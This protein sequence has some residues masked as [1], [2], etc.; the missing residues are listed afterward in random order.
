MSNLY[1]GI[2]IN[3]GSSPSSTMKPTYTLVIINEEGQVV[4][5]NTEA[6]LSRII[7]LAWENRVTSIAVD[8][9][10]EL[11]A[12][13]RDIARI[14]SLLPPHTKLVQVT[15][16]DG[17]LYTLREL[18]EK[19][20]IRIGHGK[21]PPG[22][23]AYLAALLSSKGIGTPVGL[24]GSRTRIIIA[25]RRSPRSGGWS[26]ARYRRRVNTVIQNVARTIKET[27]EREGLEFDETYR[28]SSGGLE[29][30]V[31]TVYSDIGTVSR[32]IRPYRGRD[33]QIKLKPV[34]KAHITIG[35]K[36]L[37][38]EKP[39]IIGIDP[40]ISTGI[41]ILDIDGNVLA[42]ESHRSMDRAA[43]ASLIRS[44]GTPVIVATDVKP[45]PEAVRKIAAFFNAQLYVP[46]DNLSSD[47]KRLIASTVAPDAKL[48]THQRDALAAAYKAYKELREKF[49]QAELYL[50]KVKITV[51]LDRVKE[52][53]AKGHAIAEAVEKE[54]DRI[55]GVR[56][57]RPAPLQTLS[58]QRPETP[59]LQVIAEYKEK[60]ELLE[61][62]NRQ[63]RR[64]I[65]DLEEEIER[66]ENDYRARLH[67]INIE[68]KKRIAE[69]G[70]YE[71]IKKLES[72]L[73]E[74]RRS[75]NNIRENAARLEEAIED[76]RAGRVVAARRV[77]RFTRDGLREALS[78]RPLS[79]QDI[80][81]LENQSV[82]DERAIRL[83]VEKDVEAV[84]V[85]KIVNKRLVTA[86][87]SRGVPVIEARGF[88]VLKS[89]YNVLLES[90]I[91]E[92]I[93]RRRLE[94]GASRLT[95]ETLERMLNA[96][97]LK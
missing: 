48:D 57:S 58:P 85:D 8:N 33:Y 94:I 74:A 1:M 78:E 47:E 35:T 97:R 40:G 45:A 55:I 16:V 49:K 96:Y 27:L 5:K 32:V 90:S 15:L 21:L 81:Y 95:E 53:I 71:R 13:E 38:S 89:R 80:I 93:R 61:Y 56:P 20:G 17:R 68:V 66:I 30:A 39:L 76:L 62:I 2:D 72:S 25:R 19:T 26:Q 79:G 4:Y 87:E 31:F 43:I 37:V 54:I 18:A 73:E 7:R 69:A 50:E 88:E 41:A 14:I 92:K 84:V 52:A 83:L 36:N 29:S 82:Y 70:L 11:G 77:N 51:D 65:K 22:K 6:T 59:D 42:V 46:P 9:I 67:G 23:T 12:T 91:L 3:P 24:V 86:L 34:Y 60:I 44:Y 10:F 28:S 63:L 75:L 64:K